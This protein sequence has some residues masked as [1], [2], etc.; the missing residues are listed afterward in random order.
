MLANNKRLLWFLL[1][2]FL[3]MQTGA[4]L[5]IHLEPDESH[6]YCELCAFSSVSDHLLTFLSPDVSISSQVAFAGK[7]LSAVLPLS[8][9]VYFSARA[10][11]FIV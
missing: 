5:H 9:S 2:A 3:L 10:P 6:S 4:A 8:E 1:F 7:H 11:P